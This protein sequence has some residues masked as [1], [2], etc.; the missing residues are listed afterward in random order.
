V[1]TQHCLRFPPTRAGFDAANQE[2]AAL[3]DARP[4]TDDS[5]HDI[6]LIFDEV[7]I[8][9]M[10]YGGAHSDVNVRIAFGDG[11]VTLAFE[12]DGSPFDPCVHPEPPHPTCLEEAPTGGRGIMLVRRLS[13]RMEYRLTPAKRNLL[14]VSVPLR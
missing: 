9:I 14:T 4:I 2:L 7:V 13:S 5:R 8:N 3:L 10:R 1:T 6:Q 12:D 11:E